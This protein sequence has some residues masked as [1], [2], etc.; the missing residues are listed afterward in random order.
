MTS[1]WYRVVQILC[2]IQCIGIF[3]V[4]VSERSKVKQDLPIQKSVAFKSE[5][6]SGSVPPKPL[7][8]LNFPPPEE[9]AESER[10]P[11]PKPVQENAQT[12]PLNDKSYYFRMLERR[13]QD[14]TLY[15]WKKAKHDK[16]KVYRANLPPEKKA[17]N[18]RKELQ[19]KQKR[20]A[21]VS[22]MLIIALY[23]LGPT[24]IFYF[25]PHSHQHIVKR[26]GIVS[27]RLCAE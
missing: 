20:I 16:M 4:K 24:S 21:E 26:I 9:D 15:A 11:S 8:D 13:K 6:A 27:E 22:F 5:K 17:E 25:D 23:F 10:N 19:S 1:F 2:L 18:M 14:G 3:A 12:I 7:P